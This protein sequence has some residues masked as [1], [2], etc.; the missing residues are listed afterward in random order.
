MRV[1]C[2]KVGARQ[3]CPRIS[4]EAGVAGAESLCTC[5]LLLVKFLAE[6]LSDQR[7]CLGPL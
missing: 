5:M 2:C 3:V 7:N 1:T 6:E 4:E